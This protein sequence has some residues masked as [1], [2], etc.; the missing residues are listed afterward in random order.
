MHTDDTSLKTT[1]YINIGGV[2]RTKPNIC[3]GTFLKKIF[4]GFQLFTVFPKKFH[5]RCSTGIKIR[6]CICINCPTIFP[7]VRIQSNCKTDMILF[8]H[9]FAS[10]S[11]SFASAG[12]YVL[13]I[14][15]LQQNYC[16]WSISISSQLEM[17]FDHLV[18]ML[19]TISNQHSTLNVNYEA[20]KC[21]LSGEAFSVCFHSTL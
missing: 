13:T 18:L 4:N 3:D 12:K 15:N 11:R 1:K 21:I 20:A 5:R 9:T 19:R 14:T 6:L 17:V 10:R 16:P 7:F 2:F 8:L